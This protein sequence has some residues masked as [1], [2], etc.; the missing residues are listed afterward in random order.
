MSKPWPWARLG[1]VLHQRK[2]FITLDDLAIYRRP[3]VQL[4]AQG[5]V[6]RDEVPG[7]Q[8]KTKQQQVCRAGDFLV[9]E[10]DAK[11]GGFGLV[12]SEL[13]GA[14]VSSHYFLFE[15]D[16]NMLDRAFL[17][18]FCRTSIFRDQITAQ[19]STNYA[20]IRPSHVLGYRMPL[21]SLTEQ[22]N[23]LK[24]VGA[25]ATKLD[26]RAAAVK[27]A[28]ADL[29]A[30]LRSMITSD[31]DLTPTPMRNLVRLRHLDVQVQPT[32]A[33]QFAGVYSFGRGV[34][35]A[36]RKLG[37][38]FAYARL[39]TLRA[40]DFTYPKLMAWEGAFGIVPPACE[41]C[42]VSP[43]FPVFEVDR[44]QVLP[45]VLDIH[46]RDP[47]VWPTLAGTST[48]TNARR[49]RLNPRA[50]LAYPFPLPSSEVQ[51]KVGEVCKE[52]AALR[53]VRAE[54]DAEAA[55][56]LPSLLAETFWNGAAPWAGHISPVVA[57]D[58]SH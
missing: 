19:G 46:F 43:E 54:A 47:S 10:I 31:P 49:R 13:D 26:A 21:P 58:P 36:Q 40:G 45:E 48:G 17:G 18:W 32:G 1:E 27:Q 53:R 14:I 25:V 4:H 22:R 39:T 7:G 11:V 23:V 35:Q 34:F 16:Q 55:Q 51:K 52:V 37:T 30:L 15:V 6:L 56:L 29:D 41:G 38:D 44:N 5:V 3:R 24:Q 57:S 12:P 42:V 2:E 8:I 33:Y 50:L 9:A 28:E 20:A